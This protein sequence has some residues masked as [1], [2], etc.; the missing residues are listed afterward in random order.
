M[1]NGFLAVPPSPRPLPSDGRGREILVHEIPGRR[2]RFA[3]GYH[4]SSFQDW[5]RIWAGYP[6]FTK[7]TH[8]LGATVQDSGFKV[9]SCGNLRNEANGAAG[10][11]KET[12]PWKMPS[13]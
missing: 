10:G 1:P 9:Q 13:T 8:P 11:Q 12:T 5:R 6:I 3:L 4:R 2:W 7:Q